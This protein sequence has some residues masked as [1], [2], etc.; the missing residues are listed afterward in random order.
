MN[1]ILFKRIVILFSIVGLIL[2]VV[3]SFFFVPEEQSISSLPTLKEGTIVSTSGIIKELAV[4]DN[5]VQFQ[6]C[7]YS[8]CI[9]AVLFNPSNSQL[10]VLNNL[11]IT[12]ENTRLSGQYKLYMDNPEIIVYNIE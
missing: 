11:S 9:Q 2:L 7:E 1:E 8:I 10:D 6:L 5:L 3:Y 12:K 4:K